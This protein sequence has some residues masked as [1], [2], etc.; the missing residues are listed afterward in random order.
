MCYRPMMIH[1]RFGG[2]QTD[3]MVFLFFGGGTQSIV[4]EATI[5]PTVPA[6]DDDGRC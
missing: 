2:T 6:P 1:R 4:T 5:W 3:L